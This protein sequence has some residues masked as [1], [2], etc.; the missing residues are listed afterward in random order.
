MAIEMSPFAEHHWRLTFGERD[1]DS[2]HGSLSLSVAVSVALSGACMERSGMNEWSLQR[3]F[4]PLSSARCDLIGSPM[5][6]W[7]IRPAEF[8]TLPDSMPRHVRVVLAMRASPVSC[9]RVF[10]VLFPFF[11]NIFILYLCLV[12]IIYSWVTLGVTQVSCYSYVCVGF[13]N[14]KNVCH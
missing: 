12:Y 10:I 6:E 5:G 9:Y 13:C 2:C 8:H 7:H 14:V 1:G 11:K 3:S 4:P